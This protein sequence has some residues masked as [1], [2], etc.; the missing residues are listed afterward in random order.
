LCQIPRIQSKYRIAR[1]FEG[2]LRSLAFQHTFGESSGEDSRYIVKSSRRRNK[3]K[4]TPRLNRH[5][6]KAI[7]F[8]GFLVYL[9]VK[10]TIKKRVQSLKKN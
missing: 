5:D 10:Q 8:Q 7:V 3:N 2:F 4:K 1:G 6:I 9:R